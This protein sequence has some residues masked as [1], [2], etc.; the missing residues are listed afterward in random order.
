MSPVVI[1]SKLYFLM[2]WHISFK[3]LLDKN[4]LKVFASAIHIASPLPINLPS[5]PQISSLYNLSSE[6]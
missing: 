2:Y 4:P 3:L 6:I 1:N 5:L